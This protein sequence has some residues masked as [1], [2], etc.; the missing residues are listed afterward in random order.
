MVLLEL[1]AKYY[2]DTRKG[3]W[4]RNVDISRV[5]FLRLDSLEPLE[6]SSTAQHLVIQLNFLRHH[7]SKFD[8]TTL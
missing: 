2:M 1:I 6:K 5:P 3:G 4:R 7:I 8:T